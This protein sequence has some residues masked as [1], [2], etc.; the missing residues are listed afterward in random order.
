[1]EGSHYH[2][3]NGKEERFPSYH[4]QLK[5]LCHTIQQLLGL[6]SAITP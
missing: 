4:L 2:I 3:R 1:M 5:S 6:L